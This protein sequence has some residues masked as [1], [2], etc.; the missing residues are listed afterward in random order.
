M[1]PT[2]FLVPV[3]VAE[4]LHG[5]LVARPMGEVEQLV[6]A[7]RASKPAPVEETAT[8]AIPP[9]HVPTPADIDYDVRS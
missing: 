9:I 3:E 5:Y 4:A 1:K 6:G 2:H 7:L 8:S